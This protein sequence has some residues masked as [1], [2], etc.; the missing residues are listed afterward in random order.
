MK[1]ASWITLMVVGVLITFFS[2]LSAINAY[3]RNWSVGPTSVTKLEATVPGTE[4]ALRGARSTAAAFGVA[5]GVL[6][7]IV[8][9]GPYRRGEVWAWWALLSSMLCLAAI[10]LLRV[11]ILGTTLGINPAVIPLVLVLVG[12]GLDLDRIRKSGG[13]T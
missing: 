1:K 3:W 4:V 8:V 5:Y 13:S 9:W 12:L 10:I 2:A 6:F 7:M 11:P